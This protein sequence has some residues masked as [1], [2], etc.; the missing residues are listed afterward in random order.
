MT[1]TSICQIGQ[2]GRYIF[3]A[4]VW[5]KRHQRNQQLHHSTRTFPHTVAC[6][7][8]T[9]SFSLHKHLHLS[10]SPLTPPPLTHTHSLSPPPHPLF[11]AISQPLIFTCLDDPRWLLQETFVKVK[12]SVA[13]GRS[14]HRARASPD[15]ASSRRVTGVTTPHVSTELTRRAI[16]WVH[17]H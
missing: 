16:C 11:R 7:E 6:P 9:P 14:S 5:S 10:A 17:I 8:T 15:R 3:T 2:R 4:Q 13:G 1:A 12:A